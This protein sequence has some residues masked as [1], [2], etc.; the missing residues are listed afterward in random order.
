M[1]TTASKNGSQNRPVPGTE[2]MLES[3][4]RGPTRRLGNRTVLHALGG[5]GKTSFAAM[6]PN[7]IGLMVG[8]ETGLET[9]I[10]SGQLPADIPRFPKPAETKLDVKVALAELAVKEHPY[11][12]VFI[13]SGTSLEKI[14]WQKTCNEKFNGDWGEKGFSSFDRGPKIAAQEW[15]EVLKWL[16]TLRE[17]GI[18]SFIIC[19]S[20]ITNFK[21]PE[22]PD[23][24]R[25][26]PTLSKYSWENLY[27][28]A[29]MVLFGN[30]S[31][32][33]DTKKATDTKGKGQGG[34][35]RILCTERRAAYDAKNRHGLPSEIECGNS[36]QEAWK[37]FVASFPKKKG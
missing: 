35:E 16:D 22:G 34:D 19:H 37:N 2:F 1:A 10:D 26:I 28:W 14:F 32:L 15:D 33:V 7:S 21:N 5:W 6:L 9:L 31:V 13:D 4:T 30:F 11:K 27:A 3:I 20:K 29:D 25:W 36:P 24:E 23:Y 8:D 18:G 12:H 17:I